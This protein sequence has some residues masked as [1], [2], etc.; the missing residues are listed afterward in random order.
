MF[1]YRECLIC[2]LLISRAGSQAQ[3][4]GL[5][6]IVGL[7]GQQLY[8]HCVCWDGLGLGFTKEFLIYLL[9]LLSQVVPLCSL[10]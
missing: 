7:L 10:W 1:I 5:R 4:E 3:D 6:S 9:S 8:H 2:N